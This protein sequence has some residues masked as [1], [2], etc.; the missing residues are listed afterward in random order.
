MVDPQLCIN[1]RPR[2]PYNSCVFTKIYLRATIDP[3]LGPLNI[4][5]AKHVVKYYPV[6]YLD[7][8]LQFLFQKIFMKIID[9]RS[10]T[11][12]QDTDHRCKKSLYCI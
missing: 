3:I 4:A 9:N 2:S 11:V 8:A 7:G 12:L 10:R 5:V 1:D 6:N